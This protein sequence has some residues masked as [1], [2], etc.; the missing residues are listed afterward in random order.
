MLKKPNSSGQDSNL[1][2]WKNSDDL[3]LLRGIMLHG[4][5]EWENIVYDTKLWDEEGKQGLEKQKMWKYMFEKIEQKQ[6]NEEEKIDI[7]K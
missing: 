2:R 1:E 4:F 5:D 7:E 6:A 3:Y